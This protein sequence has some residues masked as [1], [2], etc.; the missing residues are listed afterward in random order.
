MLRR[1]MWEELGLKWV[2]G[3]GGAAGEAGSAGGSW[4]FDAKQSEAA[5]R[6][7]VESLAAGVKG[8]EEVKSSRDLARELNSELVRLYDSKKGGGSRA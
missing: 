7:R 5:S 4:V 2:E 1:L 6:W 3:V 8:V